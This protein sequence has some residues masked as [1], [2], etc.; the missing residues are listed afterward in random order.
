MTSRVIDACAHIQWASQL[1]LMEYMSKGWREFLGRPGSFVGEGGGVMSAVPV[2]KYQHPAGDHLADAWPGEGGPPGSDPPTLRAQVLGPGRAELAVVG[3]R[4]AVTVP[5]F[6][7]H[8]LALTVAK[9]ANDWMLDR[10]LSDG[11]RSLHGLILAPTQLP[12]EAAAEIRRIGQ[13]SRIVGVQVAGNGM[14]KPFGHP[15]YHPIYEAAYELDLPVVLHA[16]GDATPEAIT[17]T[18]GGGLPGTW[19]EYRV[20]CAQPIMTHL[21]SL[22]AQGVLEKYPGLRMLVV[23]CGVGWIPSLFWRFDTNYKTFR[24]EVPWLNAKPSEYLRSHVRVGTFPLDRAPKP[25][26]LQRHMAMDHPEELLCYASGYPDRD[27]DSVKLI[28][29]NL[30]QGWHDKV[31]SDN[32]CWLFR[33]PNT[34]R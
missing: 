23:G 5:N 18:A 13:H 19:V 2:H 1:E 26:D 27:A 8:Y 32:S 16:G 28:S 17:H 20:L 12:E 30:P 25:T 22:I 11:D 7:N 6:P 34:E 29:D 3:H 24:R 9:A 14:G 31:L 4:A 15:V 21:V 10:W 33:W